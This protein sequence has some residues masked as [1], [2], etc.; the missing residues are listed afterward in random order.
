VVAVK[1]YLIVAKGKHQGLPI[2]IEIDL[3]MVG[4]DPECQIRSQ[5]ESIGS[6]HCAFITRDRKVFVRDMG[7]GEPTIV[8]DAIVPEN[9]EWPLHAGDQIHVGPLAFIIQ[10]HE[11]PLSQRDL[12]EWALKCLDEA[13]NK[14]KTHVLDELTL[15]AN[16]LTHALDAA[17]AAASILD[18]LNAQ[19]GVVRGRLRIAREGPVTTVRINDTY[20]VAESEL[21]LISKELHEN[22]NHP[23][24]R[25]LIDFKN[26]RR[27][28]STAAQIFAELVRWL[29]PQGSTLAICRLRAEFRDMI[30]TL[31]GDTIPIFP[32]KTAALTAD[33]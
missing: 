25:V 7:S 18:R 8:N 10:F 24:L 19:R 12:E 15:A 14:E 2:P 21:A 16:P 32:D 17:H 20:L 4:S 11:K 6:Q 9:A 13:Q 1:F 5:H 3:F 33:W 30:S 29:R 28:S 27:M 26:V 22:L 23:N 31:L